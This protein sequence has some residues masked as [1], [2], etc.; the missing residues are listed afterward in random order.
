LGSE[1]RTSSHAAISKRARRGAIVA[2]RKSEPTMTRAT[3]D[4][5]AEFFGLPQGRS[6]SAPPVSQQTLVDTDYPKGAETQRQAETP[7]QPDIVVTESP[8]SLVASRWPDPADVPSAAVEPPPPSFAVAAV[9]PD[10]KLDPGPADLTPKAAPVIPTSVETPSKGT[11]DSLE[12][13]LLATLG[14]IVLTGFAGSSVFLL[15]RLRRP[16]QSRAS[17]A[18]EPEWPLESADHTRLPRW[19]EPPAAGSTRYPYRAHEAE[20]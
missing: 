19:L 14:A 7:P 13:L 6:D 3:A 17:L 5:Y 8:Q 12:T 4:A 10:E 18:R 20:F 9:T 11:P 2:S 16:P 15:A 1:T